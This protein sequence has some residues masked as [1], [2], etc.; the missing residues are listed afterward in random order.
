MLQ[1]E[2]KEDCGKYEYQMSEEWNR[3][4]AIEV[5][6]DINLCGC[7]VDEVAEECH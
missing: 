4:V 2:P 5:V 1:Q 7:R 6:I 3:G